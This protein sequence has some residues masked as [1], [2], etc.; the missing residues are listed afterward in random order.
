MSGEVQIGVRREAQEKL[1]YHKNANRSEF[2]RAPVLTAHLH[3]G[4]VA[5]VGLAPCF[6]G[7]FKRVRGRD[8]GMVT[9]RLDETPQFAAIGNVNQQADELIFYDTNNKDLAEALTSSKELKVSWDTVVA[10][11]GGGSGAEVL[12]LGA[13]PCSPEPRR[14]AD[15]MRSAFTARF[16]DGVDRAEL[17]PL[18]F[19][20]RGFK[21]AVKKVCKEVPDRCPR[22]AKD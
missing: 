4:G 17:H 14:S 11:S 7:G 2:K 3:K 5:E 15:L 19:D 18:H 13:D 16:L 10:N 8:V 9:M 22:W 6:L 20:L 1:T 21:D 12:H